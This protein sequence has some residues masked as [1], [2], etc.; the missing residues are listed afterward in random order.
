MSVNAKINA[1]ELSILELKRRNNII[2]RMPEI[3]RTTK[4]MYFLRL[5]ALAS[6]TFC[7][8]FFLASVFVLASVYNHTPR[9]FPL[10]ITWQDFAETIL[11]GLC[12]LCSGIA[13]GVLARKTNLK[14]D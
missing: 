8:V 12:F 7:G 10:F 3:H 9:H 11:A 6:T 13:Y 5:L 1:S 14:S 2:E 4:T